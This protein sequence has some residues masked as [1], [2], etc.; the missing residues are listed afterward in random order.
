[1]SRRCPARLGHA[2]AS[3]RERFYCDVL[4]RLTDAG[5]P[6]LVGGAYAL[7]SLTGINLRTKDLDIFVRPGDRNRLLA[8]L[9]AAGY[10]TALPFPHWLAKV[11]WREELVDVIFNSGNGVAAVDDEWFAHGLSAELYGIPVRLCPI[12]E[13]IWSKAF[14]MERERYDGADIAHLL[15]ACAERIDWGRLLRRFGA[16]WPVLF[17]HLVLFGYVYPGERRRIPTRRIRALAQ[18]L[19]REWPRRPADAKVCMGGLLSRAQYSPD[20]Y[21]WGYDDGRIRPRGAM[22]VGDASLWTAA[23][24]ALPRGEKP[25]RIRQTARA[26]RS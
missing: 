23:A 19:L 2:A 16:H 26:A 14:I 3:A 17:S 12:E 7:T 9:R 6:F 18:R 15:R 22:S 24:A 21:D 1:V 8:V 13:T 4:A 25:P 10:R 11:V 20:L 5:V